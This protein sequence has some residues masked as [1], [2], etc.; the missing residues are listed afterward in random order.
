MTPD[1]DTSNTGGWIAGIFAS[2]AGLVVA[3]RKFRVGW[4]SDDVHLRLLEAQRAQVDQLHKE[5]ARMGQQNGELAT[6]L[7]RLQLIIVDLH[8][9]V[10]EVTR[11]REEMRTQL[12]ALTREI[13]RLTGSAPAKEGVAP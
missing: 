10:A 12:A 9:E 8:R 4:A 3:A 5:L 13:G 7:N 6:E 1:I 2:L 11:E